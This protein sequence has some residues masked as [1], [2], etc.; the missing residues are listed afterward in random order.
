MMTFSRIH[1]VVLLQVLLGAHAR[2]VHEQVL[3]DASLSEVA[4]AEVASDS[5]PSNKSKKNE[6]LSKKSLV[7]AEPA[8]IAEVHQA[9]APAPV[10]GPDVIAS[11]SPKV[12]TQG[13]KKTITLTAADGSSL[14]GGKAVFIPKLEGCKQ[15]SPNVDIN[16]KGEGEFTIGTPPGEYKLCF[17]SAAATQLESVEQVASDNFGSIVLDLLEATST[18]PTKIKGIFPP[19]ITVNVPTMIAFQ[20]ATAGDK[21]VFVNAKTNDCRAVDPDKDV[22]ADHNTF[23]ITSSGDYILCYKV[24]GAHDSIKQEAIE[25][26]VRAPGVSEAMTRRWERFITKPANLDCA[27]LSEIVHCGQTQKADCENRFVIEQAVG[28]RCMWD[29]QLWPPACVVDTDTNDAEKICKQ[30]SCGKHKSIDKCWVVN[31]TS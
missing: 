30:G 8:E 2:Q 18:A 21:A 20:G 3:G 15:A 5:K 9:P 31:P 4:A 13:L 16:E 23:T 10:T 29:E 26:K 6:S 24:P 14:A 25:L 28:Y 19:V 12:A 27:R 22:G 11:I 7:E 1:I 17:R